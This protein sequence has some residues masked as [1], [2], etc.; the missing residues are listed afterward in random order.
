MTPEQRLGGFVCEVPVDTSWSVSTYDADGPVMTLYDDSTESA[1]TL[2]GDALV[3]LLETALPELVDLGVKRAQ[4][5]AE[6]WEAIVA[7]EAEARPQALALGADPTCSD[8]TH[9]HSTSSCLGPK[10]LEKE[11]LATP[12]EM[13]PGGWVRLPGQQQW[14]EIESMGGCDRFGERSVTLK[15]GGRFAVMAHPTGE[16][17][18]YDKATTLPY[19]TAAEMQAEAP[20][21]SDEEAPK[22]AWG[23][24]LLDS[25]CAKPED[26]A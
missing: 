19:R 16:P 17:W 26:A 7:A 9:D 18:P 13:E 6:F 15:G 4:A 22:R 2:R 5:A 1:V 12:D 24:G 10:P 3:G 25:F 21:P 23:N 20:I 11:R 8:P 14:R